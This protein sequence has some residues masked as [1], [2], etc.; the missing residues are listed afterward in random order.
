MDVDKLLERALREL[1]DDAVSTETLAFATGIRRQAVLR[2]LK[3]ME[4]YGIVKRKT[5]RVV[6]FW[7]LV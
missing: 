1:E 5:R 6:D 4:R 7:G 2:R 3:S